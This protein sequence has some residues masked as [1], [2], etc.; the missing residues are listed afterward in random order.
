MSKKTKNQIGTAY[1][2]A[3]KP[4]QLNFKAT[5]LEAGI[6]NN[7]NYWRRWV[8]TWQYYSIVEDVP[9]VIVQAAIV[10][11]DYNPKRHETT[12]VM[13]STLQMQPSL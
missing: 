7:V 4:K 9:Y 13:L 8:D 5:L 3:T 2:S 10:N 1:E 6:I 11:L 12:A